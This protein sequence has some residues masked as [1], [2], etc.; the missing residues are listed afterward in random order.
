[1]V[2]F[3]I[4]EEGVVVGRFRLREDRDIAFKQNFIESNRSGFKKDLE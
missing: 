4:I 2:E 1:M 3:Q